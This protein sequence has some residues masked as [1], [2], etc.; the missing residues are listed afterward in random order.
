MP[1]IYK[2]PGPAH[3]QPGNNDFFILDGPV[4][5]TNVNVGPRAAAG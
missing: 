5:S 4:T 2:T 3:K 1:F